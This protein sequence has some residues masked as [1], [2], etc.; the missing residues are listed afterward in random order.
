MTTPD[1]RL[2]FTT[3]YEAMS[4]NI[5]STLDDA[6]MA[7]L[8]VR[9]TFSQARFQLIEKT[10]KLDGVLSEIRREVLESENT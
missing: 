7:Y 3:D 2:I 8:E 6:L 10:K 4:R 9:W 1:R 5:L